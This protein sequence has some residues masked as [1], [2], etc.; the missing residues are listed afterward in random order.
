MLDQWL[1]RTEIFGQSDDIM[2]Y[3]FIVI[4]LLIQPGGNLKRDLSP[5]LRPIG[6]P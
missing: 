6:K 1:F 3:I 5:A 4:G 2:K